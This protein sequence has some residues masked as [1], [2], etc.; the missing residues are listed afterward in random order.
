MLYSIPLYV[1]FR[2]MLAITLTKLLQTLAVQTSPA[3]VSSPAK[4]KVREN[5]ST[6]T[7]QLLE[8]D[9]RK[10]GVQTKRTRIAD[11]K[12]ERR[13][14]V[15]HI[16]AGKT[17]KEV[18]RVGK[19]KAKK[20]DAHS[21]QQGYCDGNFHGKH[22]EKGDPTNSNGSDTEI[23]LTQLVHES[24]SVSNKKSRGGRQ[25]AKTK[26]YPAEE[27]PEQRDLRT[28]FVGNLPLDVA[29]KKVCNSIIILSA[30]LNVK[31]STAFAQAAPA[32][33]PRPSSIRQDRVHSFPF[34]S[35]SKPN[36]Q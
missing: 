6:C 13:E 19:D 21:D 3:A 14:K 36:F 10:H 15:K 28:I 27:T 20:S 26:F 17:K 30:S 7:D 16:T 25:G 11:A 33:H 9:E 32:S 29:R 4:R 24:L 2:G 34:H 35:I 12:E 22:A 31:E 5:S 8:F 23:D 18:V 1:P